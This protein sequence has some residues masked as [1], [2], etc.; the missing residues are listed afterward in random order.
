MQL[1]F[2]ISIF[3]YLKKLLY[4]MYIPRSLC[5]WHPRSVGNVAVTPFIV[6]AYLIVIANQFVNKCL[7]SNYFIVLMHKIPFCK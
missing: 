2:F 4:I 5:I 7:I 6:F 3:G 1:Q